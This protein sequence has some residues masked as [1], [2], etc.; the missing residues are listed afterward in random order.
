MTGVMWFRRDLRLGANPAWSAATRENESVVALFVLDPQLWEGAG[1]VR[2]PLL[3]AHLRALD[4]ELQALGGR[5]RV[6]VGDPTLVVPRIGAERFYWNDDYTPYATVRDDAV[7]SAV[8]TASRHHGSAVHPPGSITTGAGTPYK[9]F[10]PFSKQ[11]FDKPLPV[12][13]PP[14]STAIEANEGDGIP[15]AAPPRMAGGERSAADRLG[16]F[17]EVI[18][19]YPAVRNRPDLDMT[20]R[21]SA[22]LKFGTL[23][24]VEVIEA[25]GDASAARKAF[26][27]QIAW[28]DFWMHALAARPDLVDSPMRPEFGSIA[29]RN[30]RDEFEA[31]AR[32][33]TGY[34]I[35]DAG[36]RQLLAEGWMHNRVRMIVGS[37]LV[38]DLLIDWRWGE[39]HFRKH[40]VDGDIAQN[41]GNWQWVAGTGADAA[42]YFRIFNPVT[43][44]KKHDPSGDYVR[45]W[46]PEL[47][48]LRGDQV[49]APWECAPLELLAADVE[50]G[51]T[52]PDPIVD[53]AAARERTLEAY[54]KARGSG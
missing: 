53:H 38:K 35:V 17:L 29:W 14:G 23:S 25:V 4:A 40:L 46:V 8:P 54:A 20:S 32:G 33:R 51:E 37:F 24:P 7:T 41:V 39:R 12:S 26:I 34:P 16:E 28:R 9:V 18:D 5:L 22:D 42:P 10:T 43:Q 45:R 1:P 50:L 49:H 13:L 19:Q 3:A 11:W 15:D 31:W 21:L 2:G 47:A 30:D 36:M 6:E 48:A 52:Y 44:G 27:R